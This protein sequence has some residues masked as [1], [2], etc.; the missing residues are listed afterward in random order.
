MTGTFFERFSA[1]VSLA[2]LGALA[3]TAWLL[4][5]LALRPSWDAAPRAG[6]QLNAQVRSAEVIQTDASG[7]PKYRIQ[8]P[9]LSLFDDGRSEMRNPLLTALRS[10]APPVRA[11]ASRAEVSAN[12]SAV[13]LRGDA[14]IERQAYG[15][16]PEVR[17]LTDWVQ[18][19]LN[20][21]TAETDAPVRVNQGNTILTG[22][23][24]RFNQRTEQIEILSS[25]QMVLPSR[26]EVQ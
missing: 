11:R 25:T 13:V 2:L 8:T 10:D 16:E 19:D 4:S 17:I 23:G 21:Q 12:Q 3:M 15:T 22:V 1:V 7:R 24:M 6:G 9:E 26:P 20:A 18:F 5:Q 14:R